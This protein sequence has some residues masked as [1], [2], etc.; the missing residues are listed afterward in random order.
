MKHAFRNRKIRRLTGPALS[1]V[2]A[3][4]MFACGAFLDGP[5]Y[6]ASEFKGSSPFSGAD[7]DTYYHNGRFTGDLIVNGVDISDW[8]SKNCDFKAARDAGV[9]F[10]IMRV[11]FS[12]LTATS[13][14]KLKLNRDSAFSS[15]YSKAKA[16]N[17]MVGVYVFSQATTAA[18]GAKEAN[19]A[20]SRLRSLGIGPED[21]ELPVYMDYEFGY[22]KGRM[23]NLSRTSATNAAVGFCNAVKSAG[24]TP[25]IY[26]S[27]SF[28]N[29]Y[30]N[31][32]VFA[33]DV[34]LWCAQYY[35]RC[36]YGSSYSKWQYSSSTKINGLLSYTGRQGSI[37]ADFWYID[38]KTAAGALT[39]ITGR[40]SLSFA[41][42]HHPK[43]TIY[44]GENVLVEGKDYI[45]GGIRNN[46]AGQGYAYIKGIG[47]YGGYALIPLTIGSTSEG[48]D[49]QDLNDACA[50]YLTYASTE[51]SSYLKVNAY[52]KATKIK[53]LK[54][55]KKGF[56]IK[57]AKKNKAYA[58]GYQVRYSR[59]KDMSDS[60]TKTIGSKYNKVRK[61]IKTGVRKKN[62]Y[63]Q[64]RTYKDSGGLRFYSGWSTVRKVKTK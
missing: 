11:S 46:K 42:A 16:N 43:F 49:S 45:V 18:E 20:I 3:V 55:K 29:T 6:A 54:G 56:Y 57:V 26:A 41:D 60:V 52:A 37:D 38:R 23:K 53:S 5:S 36:E 14:G 51:M 61:T 50:N 12:S 17:L 58:S 47:E 8:Q 40:N 13:S 28:F 10:A 30:I 27:L 59:S 44:N 15:Q 25:G 31:P 2:L 39:R 24:Y 33:D 7:Y 19:Y 22:V 4:C 64:V 62:Y 21:L 9:D 48:D 32:G 63:V 34:D 1:L 35:K